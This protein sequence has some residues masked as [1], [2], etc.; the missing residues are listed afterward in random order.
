MQTKPSSDLRIET[1]DTD[2]APGRGKVGTDPTAK[3]GRIAAACLELK[4]QRD[5]AIYLFERLPQRWNILVRGR[6]TLTAQHS[7]RRGLCLQR[8]TTHSLEVCIM[9]DNR[10]A[11]AGKTHVALDS[12][13]K[14]DCRGKCSKA[15]FRIARSMQPTMGKPRRTRV[16]RIRI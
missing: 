7:H 15:V 11:V 5:A 2:W 14:R 9:E 1:H 6:Q 3:Q 13:A 10:R 12:R 4:Q 8:D 16:E